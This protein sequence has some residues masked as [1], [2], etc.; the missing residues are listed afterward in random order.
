MNNIDKYEALLHGLQTVISLGIHYLYVH[1][2]SKI[3]VNQMMKDLLYKHPK[4]EAYSEEVQKLEHKF[5][6][7]ELHHVLRC[8]NNMEDTLAKLGFAWD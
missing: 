7:I 8:D 3:V 4:M 5:D 2:D 1:G 6:V